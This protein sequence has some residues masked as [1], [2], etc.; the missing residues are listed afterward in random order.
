MCAERGLSGPHG[1]IRNRPNL[2]WPLVISSLSMR[3]GS[4]NALSATSECEPRKEIFMVAGLHP[5]LS[6]R[7]RAGR[8]HST[9][10]RRIARPQTRPGNAKAPPLSPS[11]RDGTKIGCGGC[12]L[13]VAGYGVSDEARTSIGGHNLRHAHTPRT[14][15]PPALFHGALA[16]SN[17]TSLRRKK[18]G[19]KG[20]L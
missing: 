8:R 1:A 20:S 17:I 6:G 19:V 9:G 7:S 14:G 2:F 5:G 16:T 15:D 13:L 12:D 18:P 3:R 11:Y 4:T 10:D